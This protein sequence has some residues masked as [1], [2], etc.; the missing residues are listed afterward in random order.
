[1]K[2]RI[3]KMNNSKEIIIYFINNYIESGIKF[4]QIEGV[5][6]FRGYDYYPKASIKSRLSE[7][8]SKA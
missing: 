1:M 3:G 8:Q 7:Q 2:Q 5:Q 6:C 4:G